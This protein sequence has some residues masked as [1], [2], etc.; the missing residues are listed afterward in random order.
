MARTD[1]DTWDLATSVGATAT[2]V[3]AGRARATRD[4]LIDD[5]F[6]EP[7]VRAV[8]VDFMTRWA[9]GELDSADVDE[10]GAA[11]GMQR[12]TDM[13]AARTRYIDAFF[14]EAG[15]AGIGQVVILASGLDARAYRLPW[16][17]GTTVFEIDQP[18]VLEFKAAT[19][20]DLGAEP[21]AEVRNVPVD[22]RHDWPSALRQA[23]F[24]AGRPAAWAAEG[25][26]GFLPPEAQDRLLDNITELSADGSQLV[27]EVFANTGTSGDALNAASEKWR[28]GGLDI[29]LGDL[30][31]PGPRNDVATYLQQKGWQP[32][33]TPLNQLLANTGL[34]LQSTDP[35]A[36]FAQNYYC[37]AVRSAAR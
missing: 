6:A 18:Q 33:R 17:A 1:D 22:L 36:P 30:G 9:A 3:A 15:A 13:M 19:I 21:T 28:Q 2:M 10:P 4:G 29:A 25:L 23:G 7:L 12:M 8:G 26:I 5:R 35:E 27:A 14:A 32:V 24:D 16:P 34:P 20:A 37:T 11:W 31:F